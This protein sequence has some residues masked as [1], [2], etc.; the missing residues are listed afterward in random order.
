MRRSEERGVGSARA[1]SGT[2]SSFDGSLLT[3]RSSRLDVQALRATEFPWAVRRES[4]YL[5]SASTGPL[6]A[7]T[8]RAIAEFNEART[9]PHRLTDAMVF[10]MLDQSRA[11]VARLIGAEP[12]EIAL[13]ANTG[14]GVNLAAFALP[15]ER[16]DVVLAPDLEFPANVYPW[17]AAAERR[18]IEFRRLPLVD[19]LPD[20]PG[21]LLAIE[22]EPRVKV[23][24]VTWVSF[25]SGYRVDLAA[26]SRACRARGAWLVV[27]AIQG[28]GV[29][30][31]DVHA[32]G[33]DILTCGAQKWLLSPW[34][35]GF[36]YVREALIE[37]LTPPQ[38]SWMAFAGTDDF[39][40]L[41]DYRYEW[42]AD[43]RR[44]E[45]ITLPYQDFAGMN[46]S[47]ALLEELGRDAVIAHV[48]RAATRIVKWAEG[49]DDLTLVTPADPARRAGIVAVRPRDAVAASARLKEANVIHSLR[50]GA[51]R[52]SPHCFTTDEEI[53]RAL[54][55]LV[56][57]G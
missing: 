36:V 49:R 53:D 32:D 35:S 25:V 14:Y 28:V 44:F 2:T 45:Q 21:L 11:L 38:V 18:G 54:A 27:D 51:I 9:Q 4:I 57:S 47:L 48:E 15:L 46:A 23:V 8:V 52:L 29:A 33:V 30:P 24:T 55:L 56:R 42:R 1:P 34:G 37:T 17:M 16:G 5:N 26:L 43:A 10:G 13:A 22:R 39:T 50:E 19:G 40:R 12:H 41:T 3:P 6:P 20:E 7:R 31:L